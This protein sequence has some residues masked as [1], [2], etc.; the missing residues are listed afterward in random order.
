M[1][2]G[3][4]P[5]ITLFVEGEYDKDGHFIDRFA[6]STIVVTIDQNGEQVTK[7]STGNDVKKT[8]VWEK[9]DEGQII[10]DEPIGTQ[11]AIYLSQADTL[12]FDVGKAR[13]QIRWI[14]ILQNAYVSDISDIDLGEV[15]LER[16][17]EYGE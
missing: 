5:I 6:N 16:E 9:D 12:K 8:I 1:R 3:S 4:T 15:L 14:D 13:V 2:R 17:I 7:S 11:I 10:G